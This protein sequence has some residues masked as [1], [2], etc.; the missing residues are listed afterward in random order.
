MNCCNEF[1]D[2]RQGRDCPVRAGYAHRKVRA[3]QPVGDDT[4]CLP[5][6]YTEEQLAVWDAEERL[7]RAELE[8]VE[9]R[10]FWLV[11]G[12]VTALV[13]VTGAWLIGLVSIAP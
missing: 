2:C 3:G 10:E 7:R 5:V 9:A 8:R 1:G 6:E 4:G 11:V 12:V 13:A